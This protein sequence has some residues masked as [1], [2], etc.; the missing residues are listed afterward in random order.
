M[1]D[2]R[3]PAVL[4]RSVPVI[5]FAAVTALVS[6][7]PA[8]GV[9]LIPGKTGPIPAGGFGVGPGVPDPE[10]GARF[11][12]L[13]VGE[14]TKLLEIS[15]DDGA[16][17]NDGTIDGAY[18]VPVVGLDGTPGGLSHDGSA[19]VLEDAIRT[20]GERRTDFAIVD[21]DR[22][23]VRENISLPGTYAFD[24]ISPDGQILYLVEYP[25]RNPNVY[26]VREYDLAQHRLLP[27]PV[28][29][30][31]EVSPGEMRGL[32]MT[33]ATSP[34]GRWEYTLYDGGGGRG[35]TPFIHTLDTERGITHCVDLPM[36]SGNEA[37]RADLG[38]TGDGGTLNVTRGG[39]TLAML[40]T[41]T[42]ALTEPLAPGL[43][44]SRDGGGIPGGIVIG[45]F[46]AGVSIL[47]GAALGLRRRRRA[48]ALPPDPFAPGEPEATAGKEPEREQVPG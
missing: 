15:M 20:L 10:G 45:A 25:S 47:V 6:A 17:T 43:T 39:E 23:R 46:A 18:R 33:R 5:A 16:V 26:A 36:V 44:V 11:A 24:A 32:P 29:V 34:D 40:D 7:S 21:P 37:L 1:P 27:D 41:E 35:D 30:A 12:A 28:L 48:A 22:L 2:R 9:P 8:L 42:F 19:L 13:P 38:L 3:E 14:K 31:H 4:R